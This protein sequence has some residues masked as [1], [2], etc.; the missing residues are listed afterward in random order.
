MHLAPLL[1]SLFLLTSTASLATENTKASITR[2]TIYRGNATPS[3]PS[4]AILH[5]TREYSLKLHNTLTLQDLSSLA[6][7]NSFYLRSITHPFQTR[8]TH[9][10]FAPGNRSKSDLFA[11]WVGKKIRLLQQQHDD[12]KE[13][14]GELV[15]VTT[16]YG[17]GNSVLLRNKN[18]SLTAL[19][20]IIQITPLSDEPPARAPSLRVILE[21][22]KPGT[23]TLDLSYESTGFD[24]NARYDILFSESKD[25]SQGFIDIT[26]WIQLINNS[27]LSIKNA[28]T[29]LATRTPRQN[30][31]ERYMYSFPKPLSL[32]AQST[33]EEEW[34]APIRNIPVTRH[35]RYRSGIQG[36]VENIL[37]VS[38]TRKNGLGFAL[39]AGNV[40]V[41]THTIETDNIEFLQE[42]Q[43]PLTPRD[44][45][46]TLFIGTTNDITVARKKL[47]SSRQEE[48]FEL[49]LQN[50]KE[51]PVTLTIEEAMDPTRR[52]EI[53][54]STHDT[55][56][57]SARQAIFSPLIPANGRETLRYTVR[58]K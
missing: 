45:E 44:G 11:H 35:Y 31:G 23:Q 51:A 39:P 8:A 42:D 3:E 36:K 20:N 4:F 53:L 14:E 41:H 40:R 49:T 28:K 9:L 21:T 46:I 34:I 26:G 18:G 47:E 48:T 33:Q 25:T 19:E 30:E 50:H 57:R 24:W 37:S 5:D 10:E 7:P 43:L 16:T 15:E 13:Y 56:S 17:T 2:L 27:S 58:Y 22:E 54:A 52:W 6:R 1:L 32:A 29:T 55:S 38:N 12:T